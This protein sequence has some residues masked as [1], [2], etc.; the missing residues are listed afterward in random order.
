MRKLFAALALIGLA[1]GGG[2]SG[3]DASTPAAG[4]A[5]PA[6]DETVP[7]GMPAGVA[8]GTRLAVSCEPE[9]FSPI[10]NS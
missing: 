10:A 5:Q 4:D 9:S 8:T 6:Q 1:C 2:E 3:G 7:V